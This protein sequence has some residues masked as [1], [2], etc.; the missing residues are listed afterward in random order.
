[1]LCIFALACRC[2]RRFACTTRRY[3]AARSDEKSEKKESA[4]KGHL[5][6]ISWYYLHLP[7]EMRW[8]VCNGRRLYPG[9]ASGD[10]Y[11]P[12]TRNLPACISLFRESK[13]ARAQDAVSRRIKLGFY[14][15]RIQILRT[16]GR[17]PTA[18]LRGGVRRGTAGRREGEEG[19]RNIKNHPVPRESPRG[20]NP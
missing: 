16:H 8:P 4:K 2:T 5:V 3:E 6:A 17:A 15:K 19:R 20:A 1:M 12:Y 10:R 13:C 9:Q 14:Y 11:P 7:G 18:R